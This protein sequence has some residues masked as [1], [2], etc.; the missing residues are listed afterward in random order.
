MNTETKKV[1]FALTQAEYKKLYKRAHG[2]NLTMTDYFRY[3][4]KGLEPKDTPPPYYFAMMSI[5]Y[6]IANDIHEVAQTAKARGDANA[7]MYMDKVYLLD[8]FIS[9][10]KQE[11]TMP[12]SIKWR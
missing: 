6:G 9:D 10:V 3:L 1:T 11:V 7:D 2:A 8:S 5:V 4:L 12:G